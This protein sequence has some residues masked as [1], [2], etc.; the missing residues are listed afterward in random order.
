[1]DFSKVFQQYLT[2]TK[3]PVLE[4]KLGNGIAGVSLDER[5]AGVRDAGESGEHQ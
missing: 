1:M 5:R 3:I 2:T 4:Y